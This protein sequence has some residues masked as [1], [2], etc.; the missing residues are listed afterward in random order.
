MNQVMAKKTMTY[1]FLSMG[2]LALGYGIWKTTFRNAYETANYSSVVKDRNFELRRY[3]DLKVAKTN[4]SSAIGG[5]G[6]FG[7]LFGY[8]SGTNETRQTIAMTTPVFML[9]TT[10]DSTRSMS[11]VLPEELSSRNIPKPSNPQVEIGNRPEGL[12]AVIR[13]SGR[14]SGNRRLNQT[15]VLEEWIRNKGLIAV[16]ETEFASYDPPWTPGFFRRN[17]ILIRVKKKR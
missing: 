12:Y 13:Y 3:P 2:V 15:A 9:D 5:D 7:R 1:V 14:D 17:E 8:I 6:S 10:D 16:G 11:F 4:T